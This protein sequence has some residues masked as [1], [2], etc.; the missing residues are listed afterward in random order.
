MNYYEEDQVDK[1]KNLILYGKALLRINKENL[2]HVIAYLSPFI[3][4]A[5]G[6]GYL[7][8]QVRKDELTDLVFQIDFSDEFLVFFQ[9]LNNWSDVLEFMGDIYHPE[10]NDDDER[11]FLEG[12]T[13]FR[14]AAR[15]EWESTEMVEA[16][17]SDEFSNFRS[18]CLRESEQEKNA[19]YD[20][21][22]K[23]LTLEMFLTALAES[24]N[25]EELQENLSAGHGPID[26]NNFHL[27]VHVDVVRE[28]IE[29]K[30]VVNLFAEEET[31]YLS[32]ENEIKIF[33]DKRIVPIAV[34]TIQDPPKVILE[35]LAKENSIEVKWDFLKDGESMVTWLDAGFAM[36][37]YSSQTIQIQNK[38]EWASP[39]S[40]CVNRLVQEVEGCLTCRFQLID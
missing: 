4:K 16:V 10:Q 34:P 31:L 5:F 29:E 39:C 37:Y 18:L 6:G 15:Y 11:L 9:Y 17:S 19:S 33:E 40:L 22:E 13:Y 25:I 35:H 32:Y 14:A 30:I 2:L 24:H 21:S 28:N 36:N 38:K 27:G 12:D 26:F 3:E 20:C 23:E 7:K 1:E 8:Y